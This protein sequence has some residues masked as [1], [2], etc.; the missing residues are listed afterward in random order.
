MISVTNF[1]KK[2]IKKS[3]KK[4]FHEKNTCYSESSVNA[5][6]QYL[7]IASRAQNNN[8]QSDEKVSGASCQR[9]M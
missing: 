1:P 2:T 4:S 6:F 5:Y 9:Y 7:I 8:V 3:R